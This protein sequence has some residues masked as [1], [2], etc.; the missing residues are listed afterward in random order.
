VSAPSRGRVA[1]WWQRRGTDVFGLSAILGFVLAYVSPS[2]KDGGSFGSFDTVI[3][4]T[5]LG[6]GAYP[7][8]PHNV[9]NGDSV[10]LMV[11][12]N[13]FDWTAI[14]HLQF[15]LW[16]DLNLLGLNQFLN[17]Q[18]AVLSL[19]D[20]ASYLAP[21]RYAFL[22]VVA[23]KLLI[24]GTGAY[25]LCRVLGLR[26]L[27]SALGG[28]TF[29]LSGAFAGWLTW[30]LSGVVA[31]LGWIA[32]LAILAYRWKARRSYMVLLALSVAFCVYGGFPEAYF[33][34]AGALATFF[35]VLAALA[36]VG[37][38]RL[39]LPG[40]ARVAIGVLAGGALSAP[41]WLPGLQAVKGSHRGTLT[42]FAGLD[43]RT[44]A[45][46]VAPGYYGL[47]IKGSTWFYSQGNYY[48]TAVFVGV[49]TLVLAGA[50]VLRWWRHPTVVALAAMVVVAMAVSY[51][52]RSF[53]VVY[54]LLRHANLDSVPIRRMRA[55]VGLPL[56]VLS[57]LGLETLLR[58]RGERRM[59]ITYWV[60]SAIVAAFV[61]LLWYRALSGKLPAARHELRLDSLW[62]PIGL[63]AACV[64]AGILFLFARR[65][66]RRAS[67]RRIVV[68]GAA[69]LFGAETAFLL[70]SGVG[71][72]TYSKSFFPVTPAIARLKAVVGSGLV[73]LDTGTP[74][75]SQTME[76][77]GFY[78]D[79]NL[80]YGV[81]EYAGHD[82]LIPQ[83]YFTSRGGMSYVEPDIDSAALAREYGIAWILQ[84]PGTSLPAP[85][86]TRYAGSFAGERL[87]AVPGAT[88]F[89]LVA[90]GGSGASRPV[91]SIEHPVTS[92]WTLTIDASAPSQLVMRVTDL[93]GWHASIDGRALTLSRY[94]G[95]MLEAAVPAGPHVIHLWYLPT[96]LVIGTWLALATLA[97]LLAW[98][99][100]P[101]AWR[102]RRPELARAELGESFAPALEAAEVACRERAAPR[103]LRKAPGPDS[104]GDHKHGTEPGDIASPA[105]TAGSTGPLT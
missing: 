22:V 46:L 33:F 45:L 82:P 27:A 83:A 89:S 66:A 78:P 4:F 15:P 56:G 35:V 69:V 57:A 50:A 98:A 97:A 60:M 96:R 55:V 24:A 47:P 90:G 81:A 73:G 58:A 62:W 2:V 43:A 59:L 17:F 70:F 74:T 28:I 20:L 61:A 3:S 38:R 32:A 6:T 99:I 31:W 1:R 52:T 18:S 9:L 63:V 79:A 8:A 75:Q 25:V 103:T 5:S 54:T 10:T 85:P 37:R 26:S 41:L 92:S 72:N 44:L 80:G 88:R 19:P 65:F 84:E 68:A 48:E 100:W 13:T 23:M 71:I 87:Y 77:V 51:Q 49:I 14:H 39:S 86:G 12:F 29:M 102:R 21:L 94:K 34:V 104:G 91:S 42:G 101:L 40:V 95:L 53:H 11:P 36:L 93:P 30:P 64:L 16:N 7:G 67:A 105:G 76:P